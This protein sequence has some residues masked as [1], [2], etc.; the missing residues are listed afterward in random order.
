MSSR[1]VYLFYNKIMKIG[2]SDFFEI[3]YLTSLLFFKTN[4]VIL[5]QFFIDNLGIKWK[6][7][8]SG[9]FLAKIRFLGL[10]ITSKS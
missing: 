3:S 7:L 4:F 5:T 9:K 1:V 8:H 10:I 6:D 2:D